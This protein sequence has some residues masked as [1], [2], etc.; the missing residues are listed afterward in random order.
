SG[1]SFRPSEPF[2]G[3]DPFEFSIPCTSTANFQ[4]RIEL[5]HVESLQL[6]CILNRRQW[7]TRFLHLDKFGH[8]RFHDRL[9][10]FLAFFFFRA[11]IAV[12]FTRLL[13]F[14]NQRH[15]F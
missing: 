11:I 14:Q 9:S 7:Q 10:R 3:R 2:C 5:I 4:S 6:C 13:F 1:Q 12:P 8:A 15:P